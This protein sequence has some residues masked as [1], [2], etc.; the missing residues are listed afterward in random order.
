MSENRITRRNGVPASERGASLHVAILAEFAAASGGAE[1]VAVESAR[2]LAEAGAAVTY[3]QAIPGPVDP[4]LDHPRVHRLDLGLPDVWSLPAWRGA[5]SGIWNGEAAARLAAALDGLP[6]P[7][8]CL[9]LH[10]WTRA[11]SPAVLPVL[12]GRGAPLVLT[13]HDYALTCPNGV[14]YRFDRAEPCTVAPLSGA[15]LAAP[16]DP[17]SRLH[18]GVRVGRAAAL[19]VAV[20]GADLDVVHVCDG[21]R[22]RMEGRSG[23]L[24]LRHHRIDNPVRVERREPAAPEAG[25][26]VAYVGRLTPE[27]GADLVA[28]AA[29]RAGLPAL[30]I[31]AGPLEA[32]LRAQGAEVLGWM[33]PEAVETILRRRAR[34]VCAPSRWVETGPLTVYEA[35]A[36]G[37]PVVAS[38]R[39]GA[40]EKVADGE[41]GFV[42]EPEVEALAGAFRA[43]R[44]D[45]LVARFGR[46]AYDRYWQAPLTLAA[47]AR[48]LLALYRRLAE[49][50]FMRQCGMSEPIPSPA[51]MRRTA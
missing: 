42:V 4:L 5:A 26:A 37:I 33:S 12:L 19:R 51:A 43:L 49:E 24:R 45:R 40:A 11:L 38:R 17:K 41:T 32:H 29:R 3:I 16:C 9:H 7:P 27:K 34:A 21:S 25:E 47:H 2:A 46:A 20:R 31:G 14:D 1:K 13:L 30:F 28:E 15:C 23:A 35:L 10:Q 44:D 8:D 39:S 18:K 36:Q 50:S 22:A 48:A 6:S